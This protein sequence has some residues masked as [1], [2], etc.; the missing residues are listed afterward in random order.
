[1]ISFGDNKKMLLKTYHIDI[2]FPVQSMC[3]HSHYKEID[4]ETAQQGNARLD[5]VVEVGVGDSRFPAPINP[6]AFDQCG[7]EI[8][9]VGHDYSTY[10]RDC[11]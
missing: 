9:I 10:Y 6:P 7:M 2:S 3:E 1:V 11:I 5:Q 4:Y 8:E